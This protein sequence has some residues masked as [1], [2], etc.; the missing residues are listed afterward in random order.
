M[1]P[2]SPLLLPEE[3]VLDDPDDD[4]EA[5][6]TVPGDL[7]YL[8]SENRGSRFDTNAGIL[9]NASYTSRWRRS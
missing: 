9:T 7:W 2:R 3:D 1:M 8:R 6:P 5:D 4:D